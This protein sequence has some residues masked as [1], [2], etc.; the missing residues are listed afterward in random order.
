MRYKIYNLHVWPMPEQ[1]GPN[2]VCVILSHRR[3]TITSVWYFVIME[4]YKIS[5]LRDTITETWYFM[6]FKYSKIKKKTKKFFCSKNDLKRNFG[7]YTHCFARIWREHICQVLSSMSKT[8]LK[9]SI[10]SEWYIVSRRRDTITSV[11]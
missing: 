8:C 3:D 10:T 11:W 4:S 7:T 2:H 9:C 5:R 6:S 1:L